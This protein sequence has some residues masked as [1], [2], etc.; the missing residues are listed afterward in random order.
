MKMKRILAGAMTLILTV[1]GMGFPSAAYADEK[2]EAVNDTREVICESIEDTADEEGISAETVNIEEYTAGNTYDPGENIEA[3]QAADPGDYSFGTDWNTWSQS[4]FNNET[5]KKYGCRMVAYSKMLVQT[6]AVPMS[7]VENGGFNPGIFYDWCA[8]NGWISGMIDEVGDPAGQCPGDFAQKVYGTDLS[9]TK[10]QIEG[11]SDDQ[12]KD[13]IMEL[14]NAGYTVILGCTQHFVCVDTAAT[15]SNSYPYIQESYSKDPGN[16]VKV[17]DGNYSLGTYTNIRYW[18]CSGS[19]TPGPVPPTP[20]PED[21]YSGK[22]GDDL[23]WKLTED[24]NKEG[25]YTLTIS[26]TGAMYDY[27]Q[28]KDEDDSTLPPWLVCIKKIKGEDKNPRIFIIDFVI[29]KGITRIG[30]YAFYETGSFNKKK[31]LILPDTLKEIGSY[32][33]DEMIFLENIT[34]PEGVT[35]IEKNAFYWTPLKNIVLPDS[36]EEIGDSAFSNCYALESVTP[37]LPSGLKKLGY[38]AFWGCSKLQST[39]TIPSGLQQ[40]GGNAFYNCSE[41]KGSLKFPENI[42]VGYSVFKN[43]SSLTGTV[44]I[45]GTM[46]AGNYVHFEDK[47][48]MPVMEIPFGCFEG[49]TGLTGVTIDEGIIS[50]GSWS[51]YGCTGL[52]GELKIPTC[53]DI[54]SEAF[55][56]CSSLDTLVFSKRHPKNDSGQYIY[57]YAIHIGDCAFENCS[58]LSGTLVLNAYDLTFYSGQYSNRAFMGTNYDSVRLEG[59][60]FEY[61]VSSFSGKDVKGNYHFHE[62]MEES[63]NVDLATFPKDVTIYYED[64]FDK[65]LRKADGKPGSA[66]SGVIK[67]LDELGYNYKSFTDAGITSPYYY[68]VEAKAVDRD[69]YLN[70]SSYSTIYMPYEPYADDYDKVRIDVADESIATLEFDE[71]HK[72]WKIIPHKIGKTD[73]TVSIDTHDYGLQT[74][75]ATITVLADKNTKLH[76]VSFVLNGGKCEDYG[77]WS[78]H[79]AD[80]TESGDVITAA[81]TSGVTDIKKLPVPVR[82]GYKFGGWYSDTTYKKAVKSIPKKT[83]NDLTLFAKWIAPYRVIMHDGETTKIYKGFTLNK[84]KA[85]AGCP[86]KRT[87]AAFTGWSLTEGSND[88]TYLNKEKLTEPELIVEEGILTL[89]LYAVWQSD[90]TIDAD[91]GGGDYGEKEKNRIPTEYTYAEILK[92]A[93]TLPKAMVRDGYKFGGWFDSATDKKITKITKT[94]CRNYVLYAKWTPLTYQITYKANAPKGS[95]VTGKMSSQKMTFGTEYD[96]PL[97]TNNF[98]MNGY[99]F[100]G[101]GLD[102]ASSEV[103]FDDGAVFDF[104]EGGYKKKVTLYAVWEKNTP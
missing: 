48:P 56:N 70:S 40:L 87:D 30:N 75:T 18:S 76:R 73:Y 3:E 62:E 58:G 34:I 85:L 81:F 88:I 16:T 104:G 12:K 2:R 1:T 45:P 93:I 31:D 57:H 99:T 97:R 25:Y 15:K 9:V 64:K 79:M 14:V 89:H 23:T 38:G 36:L 63:E 90:F 19:P 84:A 27:P 59:R 69:A 60:W 102:A 103:I 42:N 86:F 52:D 20:A 10:L 44:N 66:E 5:V 61:S 72:S 32:A 8:K 54:G 92:K 6:G 13:K 67:A 91:M 41:M 65:D 28:P 22:C 17:E 74:A 55:K 26:G 77:Y 83:A 4:S 96:N 43:C 53:C 101:W 29:E 35:K 46:W 37:L 98:T 21:E 71:K 24:S 68:I 39:L 11:W 82:E 94:T 7:D 95:K 47:P 80:I 51:F 100:K 49:C 78:D 33:F 50:I